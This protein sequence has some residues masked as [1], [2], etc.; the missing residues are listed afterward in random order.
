MAVGAGARAAATGL[1]A[2]EVVEHGDDEVVVEVASGLGAHGEGHDREPFGREVAEDLDGR[3][4]LPSL[5]G[6]AEEDRL[7]G[8]DRRGPDSLLELE[9]EPCADR[10]DDG[11]GATLLAVRGI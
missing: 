1:D 9:D 5:D 7:A 8:P 11:W 6:A 10:L 2:E 4:L 3:L